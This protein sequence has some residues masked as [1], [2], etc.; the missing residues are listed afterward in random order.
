MQVKN[1]FSTL[2][3]I[4]KSK[5]KNGEAPIWV[6]ITV[7]GERT[8]ISIKK[9]IH[10]DNW[11]SEKGLVK[12]TKE[13]ARIINNYIE[14]VRS[15]LFT[16]YQKLLSERKLVTANAIKNMYLGKEEKEHSLMGLIE[17]H[18][19]CL[20]DT[21][22]WGTMKNYHTTQK[23]VQMFLKNKLRTSDVYLSQLNYKFITDF[24]MFVK[25]HQ[26]VDHQKP[27]GQNTVMKHIERLRK[28]VNL[29]IKNE[30]LNR[31]PFAKFKPV[32]QK[33]TRNFLDPEELL[34]IENKHFSIPRL[35]QVK[36]LFVFS[37]YTGLAYI[38]VMNLTPANIGRGIDGELWL[39]TSRQKTDNSVRIPLLPK[40]LKIIEKYKE[41]PKALAEGSL[42]PAITNQKL[43]SYLKEVADLCSISKNLTF[44]L[45]RHTFATTV[46]LTNGV[47][48]ETVSK[49]LGHSSIRTTQIYAK[50]VERKVSDDMNKLREKLNQNHKTTNT[51]L[52]MGT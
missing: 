13:E 41:H 33:T 7:D 50:V 52:K 34:V 45:A 14:Q 29:A 21:L 30:W 3:W 10:P 47:P 15:Q 12:G 19:T 9:S 28:M 36:D 27:C 5:M 2:F 8:E 23:Y 26:P 20:K 1:T 31:D 43:N 17:Y 38:D 42:F 46:T 25:S 39:L 37:C 48:M 40:A 24:E 16:C 18:N 32:F 44:H 49:L 22:E 51:E 35:E 6:R 4:Y 11:N